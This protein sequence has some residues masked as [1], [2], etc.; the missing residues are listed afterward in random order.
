V[1]R[2]NLANEDFEGDTTSFRL[3]AEELGDLVGDMKMER[4]IPDR[5]NA[6]TR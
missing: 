4:P 2:E 1:R 5:S 3:G 6:F